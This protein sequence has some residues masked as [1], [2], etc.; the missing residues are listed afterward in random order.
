MTGCTPSRTTSITVFCGSRLRVLLQ[1]SHRI[2]GRAHH[3]ALI[4]LVYAGYD[5]QQRGLTRAVQT[6]YT[7]LG[8]IEK[9]DI[10]FL[11]P[12]SAGDRSCSPPPLKNYLLIVCH[13]IKRLFLLLYLFISSF[14]RAVAHR[15]ITSHLAL[16]DI[17]Q[18]GAQQHTAR[19]RHMIHIELSVQ[20]ITPRAAMRARNPPIS[21]V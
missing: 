9:R 17:A 13:K 18:F 10:C 6:D 12:A 21:S 3:L 8:A 20:M 15:I 2:A 11:A 7:D 4:A 14:F 1:I 5:L 19:A 16:Y